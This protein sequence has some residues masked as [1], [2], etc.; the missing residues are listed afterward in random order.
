[1][2]MVT[3]GDRAR[4][5]SMTFTG[6][7]TFAVSI[8]MIAVGSW[9]IHYTNE[10]NRNERLS[11]TCPMQPKTPVYLV[12]AGVLSITLLFSRLFIQVF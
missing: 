3:G 11:T 7:V 6:V 8:A 5:G 4:C 1:M 12:V 9:N 2:K 10:L